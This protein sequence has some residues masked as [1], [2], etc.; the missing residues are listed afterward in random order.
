MATIYYTIITRRMSNT[1][2]KVPLSE[3]NNAIL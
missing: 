2:Y 3:G 1:I